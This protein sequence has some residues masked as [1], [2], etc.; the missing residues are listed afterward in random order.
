MPLNLASAW[1][2]CEW[3]PSRDG[4]AWEG[5]AHFWA[6]R[7][8]VLVG[9]NGN[10]RLCASCAALPRFQRFKHRAI[11]EKVTDAADR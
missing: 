5:D 9:A 8:T 6:N 2:G 3:N 7:A 10:Y 11:V 1:D 4:E